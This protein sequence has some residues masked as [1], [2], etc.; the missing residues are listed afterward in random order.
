MDQSEKRKIKRILYG[1]AGVCL[2][3]LGVIIAYKAL[4]YVKSSFYLSIFM[5][6]YN[7]K[8]LPLSLFSLLVGV[9]FLSISLSFF[10][11]II[12][13]YVRNVYNLLATAIEG[14]HSNRDRMSDLF[15][16]IAEPFWMILRISIALAILLMIYSTYAQWYP[17]M[18]ERTHIG[19]PRDGQIYFAVDTIKATDRLNS[20]DCF[21]VIAGEGWKFITLLYQAY[22]YSAYNVT[23]VAPVTMKAL[24][25]TDKNGIGYSPYYNN[26]LPKEEYY[27]QQE[28]DGDWRR[29][30]YKVPTNAIP[31]KVEFFFANPTSNKN[32]STTISLHMRLI[33]PNPSMG[34]LLDAGGDIDY[35]DPSNVQLP[36]FMT[37]NP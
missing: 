24:K 22:H 14:L 3:L 16:K 28:T 1:V 11:I 25:L 18:G 12:L 10:I 19:D 30:V 27:Y 5:I 20:S 4:D 29:L 31:D 21:D 26:C 15:N 23:E 2:L 36:G 35:L 34:S 13:W 7:L 33:V 9:F 8:W 6:I 32:I 37:P 17:H